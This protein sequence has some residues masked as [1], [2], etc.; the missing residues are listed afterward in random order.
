MNSDVVY[1][2]IQE[3][4]RVEQ[5]FDADHWWPVFSAPSVSVGW[6]ALSRWK[7]QYPDEV[8][9]IMHIEVKATEVKI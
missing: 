1:I 2:G 5:Q 9:R 8:F 4:W 6:H 3:E 7:E